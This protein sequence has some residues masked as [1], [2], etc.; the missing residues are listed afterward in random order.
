MLY[1]SQFKQSGR[2]PEGIFIHVDLVDWPC[3]HLPLFSIGFFPVLLSCPSSTLLSYCMLLLSSIPCLLFVK[4]KLLHFIS[5]VY[6]T[7]Y[8]YVCHAHAWR[9]KSTLPGNRVALCYDPPC[10][11]WELNL[12]PLQEQQLLFPVQPCLRSPP[13]FLKTL[14]LSPMHPYLVAMLNC[15]FKA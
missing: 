13:C 5:H 14:F 2:F 3:S 11:C 6:M 7:S 8:V 15:C 4:K 9:L 12:D 10:G 1:M